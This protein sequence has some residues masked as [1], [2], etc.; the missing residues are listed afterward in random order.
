[1]LNNSWTYG[2]LPIPIWQGIDVRS[3][4]NLTHLDGDI[5]AN[6]NMKIK[7]LKKRQSRFLCN[8]YKELNQ[9]LQNVDISA[10]TFW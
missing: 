3:W 7:R 10:D 8:I 4:R 5:I 6:L 2:G 1:M 9:D